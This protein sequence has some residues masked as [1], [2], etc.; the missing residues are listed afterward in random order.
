LGQKKVLGKGYDPKEVG[1]YMDEY[2]KQY[3]HRY[4]EAEGRVERMSQEI[5]S[6]KAK[7][8]PLQALEQERKALESQIKDALLEIYLDASIDLFK[9]VKEYDIKEA[10][11][12][13]AVRAREAELENVRQVTDRLCQEVELLTQ[14]YD[15]VLKGENAAYE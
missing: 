5:E 11:L 12:D 8:E 13:Q 9:A 4:I 3:Q 1:A 6:L 7:L 2:E 14:G 10:E 15:R